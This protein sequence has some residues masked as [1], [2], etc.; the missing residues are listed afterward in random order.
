[1]QYILQHF[2]FYVL[3]LFSLN[4]F[5]YV[6]LMYFFFYHIVLYFFL[7]IKH[8]SDIL[9]LFNLARLSVPCTFSVFSFSYQFDL[10]IS[11]SISSRHSYST[12]FDIAFRPLRYIYSH[13]SLMAYSST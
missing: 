5:F 3:L 10:F 12:F 1:M 6:F 9:L 2:P 11:I 8:F 13:V 7:L 4:I